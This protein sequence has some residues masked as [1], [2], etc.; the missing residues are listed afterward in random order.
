MLEPDHT[1]ARVL[2]LPREAG[3]PAAIEARRLLALHLERLGYT[4]RERRFSFP[5]AT[6]SAFPLAGAGLGWLTL[7]Q[8]P[9]LTVAG[10][11]SWLAL[12]S[13]VFGLCAL[14]VVVGG[15]ALGWTALGGEVREDANLV[16]MRP[17]SRPKRWVVAHTDAIGFGQSLWG[18]WLTVGAGMAT[19]AAFLGLG[20]VRLDGPVGVDMVGLAAALAVA[21]CG[22]SVR[23][24]RRVASVGARDGGTGLYAALAAAARVTDGSLGLLLTGAREFGLVGA[25]IAAKEDGA[26]L[27]AANVVD[28]GI[29]DD[30]GV[31]SVVIHGPEAVDYAASLAARL[32]SQG[33]KVRRATRGTGRFTDGSVLSRRAASALSLVRGAR[34][35]AARVHTIRDVPEG[36]GFRTAAAVG[37]AVAM[38]GGESLAAMTASPS[39]R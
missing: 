24:G 27:R 34:S 38:N 9:L 35:T 19:I 2:E 10:G 8:I 26:I 29:L 1:I 37:E 18:R 12:A 30:A 33:L 3:T 14:G 7:V 25:R 39:P 15:V 23:A 11:P 4:V 17:G 6:L 20:V 31:L 32:D 36:L 16:A 5:A 28:L 21:S 13:W 22:L